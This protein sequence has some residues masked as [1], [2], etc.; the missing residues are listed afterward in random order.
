MDFQLGPCPHIAPLFNETNYEIWSIRMKA[1]MGAMGYD[2]WNSSVSGYTPPKT[3]SK[4]VAK[5]ELKRNNKVAMDAI[6]EGLSKSTIFFWKVYFS[7]RALGEDKKYL[8]G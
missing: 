5:K 8:H 2:V 4:S 7:Q 6:L 3:P 1:F